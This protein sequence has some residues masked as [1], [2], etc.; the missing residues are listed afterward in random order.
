MKTAKNSG[1]T[2]GGLAVF[3]TAKPLAAQDFR[4]GCDAD[5]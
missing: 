5:H 1:G 3:Y 2:A 4:G